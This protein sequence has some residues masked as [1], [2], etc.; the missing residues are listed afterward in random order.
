[1]VPFKG[2][3]SCIT[4]SPFKPT[5]WGIQMYVLSD[6]NKGCVYLILPYFWFLQLESLIYPELPI[7]TWSTRICTRISSN[8]SLTLRST[9]IPHSEGYHLYISRYYS[10]VSLA[11]ELLKMK[12]YLTGTIQNNKKLLPNQIRKPVSKIQIIMFCSRINKLL[13]L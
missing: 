12:C 8:Q 9:S 6:S 3:F 4:Y 7:S 5:R 2:R 1:M 11:K 10:S 13:V